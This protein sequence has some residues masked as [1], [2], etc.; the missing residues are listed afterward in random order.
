MAN[1]TLCYQ[2]INMNYKY[3]IRSL[4][5]L[6]SITL[7]QP[8]IAQGLSCNQEV[9]EIAQKIT[10]LID[11][12]NKYNGSGVLIKRDSNTYTVLT[13]FHNV[14]DPNFKYAI[15]TPDGQRYPLNV[16][17][18]QPLR[19]DVDL[20][21][22]RFNSSQ[23][24]QL[25]K[26]GNS[27]V[28]KRRDNVY[29]GGFRPQNGA[30]PIP[31][32]DCF[33]GQVSAN[34]TQA[35]IDG[36]ASLIYTNPTVK[37]MS[38]GPVLNQQGELIA[39]HVRGDEYDN[40]SMN[41]YAGVPIQTFVKIAGGMPIINQPQGG[42]LKP[43][44]YYA[45][46]GD[47]Y[48]KR[49]YKGAI[50]A[51]NEAI[52]LDSKYAEAYFRRGNARSDLGDKP[53]AIADFNQAIKINPQYAEAYNNRGNI[54]S[55]LGDK[56]TAITDYNQAIKIN[57][58]LVQ[59]YNNRGIARYELGDKQGAMAD[60]NEAIKRNPNDPYAYHSRGNARYELGDNQGAI[61]DFNQAIKRNPNLA[62][63]YI[64]RG[65]AY[66]VLGNKLQGISD[67]QQAVKLYQQQGGN[68]ES[69]RNVQDIIRKLQ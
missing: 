53:A 52:R 37:G 56:Q 47:K 17:N 28:V 51:Y 65:L 29:V 22:V 55:F 5:I 20:T 21:V 36:G 35:K 12:N 59:V 41:R 16:Q 30:I 15:V 57:P 10:V 24:Y 27:D 66:A 1:A 8:A 49:D 43:D 19:T 2:T 38:G 9:D 44:N 60:Y 31:L 45:L 3:T 14:K 68:E 50:V 61:D 58:N 39:I 46:A 18:I 6:T 40:R 48:A 34:A 33:D 64:G 4:F 62:E 63:H 26:F 42:G 11:I 25:A 67:L 13:A 54:Y 23:V 32:Y 7:T 69:L